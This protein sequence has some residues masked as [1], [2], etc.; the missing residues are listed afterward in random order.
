MA[1]GPGF[2][3][4]LSCCDSSTR[5]SGDLFTKRTPTS[6]ERPIFFADPEMILELEMGGAPAPYTWPYK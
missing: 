1:T 5:A 3:P 4:K 2:L 6:E